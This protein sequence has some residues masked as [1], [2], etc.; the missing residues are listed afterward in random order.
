V[1]A[2]AS[3]QDTTR[4]QHTVADEDE[5]AN[6]A[7]RD[8]A[9]AVE[10]EPRRTVLRGASLEP[11]ENAHQLCSALQHSQREEG[12]VLVEDL[13]HLEAARDRHTGEHQRMRGR[14]GNER[15]P[16]RPL[17][18]PATVPRLRLVVTYFGVVILP[19]QH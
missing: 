8:P 19:W 11:H 5:P 3:K 9:N 15:F 16:D 10:P 6:T 17:E 12:L 14:G 2:A 18:A 4:R 13:D 7:D 1:R